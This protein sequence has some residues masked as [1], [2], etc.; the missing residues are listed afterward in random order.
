MEHDGSGAGRGGADRSGSRSK[1]A[2][3]SA[4]ARRWDEEADA[5]MIVA[6]ELG[7][8]AQAFDCGG[9]S[10]Q[11]HDFDVDLS[12]GRRVAVEVTRHN[13]PRD[14]EA[15]SAVGKRKWRFPQLTGDWTVGTAAS[16]DVRALH[17]AVGELLSKFEDGGL[18]SILL[19]DSLFDATLQ[20]DELYDDERQD[21]RRMEVAGVRDSAERLWH[22]G[23]RNVCRLTDSQDPAGGEVSIY[24]TGQGGATSAAT[25]VNLIEDHASRKDNRA[26][27]FAASS[28]R[29]ESHLFIWVESSQHA[30]VAAI[31]LSAVLPGVCAMPERAPLLPA[32]VD[33]AWVATAYTVSRV[34]R[35]HRAEGW[36]DLGT[37]NLHDPDAG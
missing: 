7:G 37:R 17:A 20:V 9:G 6:A 13:V 14:L 5:R 19:R 28:T 32:F 10:Q 30:A 22:L 25:V 4:Q 12:D 26:K 33:A 31:R 21:R 29:D 36:R 2:E 18:H 1:R 11:R 8:T 3:S 24:R 34:W 16:P 27:L 35:Y 23:A 15:L